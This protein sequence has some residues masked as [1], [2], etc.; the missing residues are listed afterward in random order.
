MTRIYGVRTGDLAVNSEVNGS[1]TRWGHAICI[2]VWPWLFVSDIFV[3]REALAMEQLQ[4]SLLSLGAEEGTV[5]A[6]CRCGGECITMQNYPEDGAPKRAMPVANN[7]MRLAHNASWPTEHPTDRFLLR[8]DIL[9]VCMTC[10][11]VERAVDLRALRNYLAAVDGSKGPPETFL[12]GLA[13]KMELFTT[14]K[15]QSEIFGKSG[16]L[17]CGMDTH[18]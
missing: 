13:T 14:N 4:E 2:S 12:L 6:R 10:G 15:F 5:K 3:A 7:W 8:A 1:M 16:K 11:V 18:Q 17:G 9:R